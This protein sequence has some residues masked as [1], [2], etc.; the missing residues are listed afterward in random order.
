MTTYTFSILDMETGKSHEHCDEQPYNDKLDMLWQ[1][2]E[3][4]YGCDCNRGLFCEVEDADLLPCGRERFVVT[5]VHE[6]RVCVLWGDPRD[7]E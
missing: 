4:N 5:L 1:W 3:G 7:Q 2:G 6:G